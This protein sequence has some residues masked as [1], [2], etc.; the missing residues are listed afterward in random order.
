MGEL[1]VHQAVGA[2]LALEYLSGRISKVSLASGDLDV[3]Q[4]ACAVYYPL[5]ER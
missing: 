2:I 3:A 4:V 5:Y 1:R